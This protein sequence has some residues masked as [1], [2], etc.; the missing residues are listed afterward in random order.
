MALKI[1]VLV[2]AHNEVASIGATIVALADQSR[3]PDHIVIVP[4][5]CSDET[6]SVARSYVASSPVPLTVYEL[7]E[8]AHKK[9]EALNR[10]WRQFAADADIV[11][12]QDG[13]TVLAPNAV[14]A[15][16]QEFV[17]NATSV[18]TRV[19]RKAVR[20][21]GGSSSKFTM[22]GTSFLT[23]LQRSEFAKWTDTA[24]IRGWTSVLAGTGCAISGEALRQVAAR[25]DRDGPWVYTSLVEDFELTYRIRQLGYQTVV[26]PMVR[27]YTDSMKSV[28]ALWSQRMKWQVGT[29]EDLLSIGVNRLTFIDW[30]QQAFGLLS[31]FMRILWVLMLVGQ[32]AFGMFHFVWWWWTFVPLTFAVGEGIMARRIPHRD[33]L[34]VIMAVAIFP[35]E[36]FAWLRAA[37]FLAAWQEVLVSRLLGRGQKDRWSLQYAAEAK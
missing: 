19:G 36:A 4:N 13:D 32:T 33:R 9:A 14:E 8:L 28:Q 5:G 16:E 20:P 24:L 25:S 7:P 10:A 29:V 31:A 2:P 3:R 34:D 15:W 1:V 22:R 35:T 12:S 27:A 37:W 11:V 23:R 18:G 6:A 26:S 17:T 30:W 21:L